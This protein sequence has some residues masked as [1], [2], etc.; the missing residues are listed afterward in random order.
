MSMFDFWSNDTEDMLVGPANGEAQ[1]I[2]TMIS[3]SNL[4]SMAKLEKAMQDYRA[5]AA[6]YLET[7]EDNTTGVQI[8]HHAFSFQGKTFAIR[9]ADLP[10]NACLFP[11][12]FFGPLNTQPAY[13]PHPLKLLYQNQDHSEQPEVM[14]ASVRQAIILIPALMEAIAPPLPRDVHSVT[15]A[16]AEQVRTILNT[17]VP[18]DLF[19]TASSKTSFGTYAAHVLQWLHLASTNSEHIQ[20]KANPARMKLSPTDTQATRMEALLT[21]GLPFKPQKK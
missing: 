7:N 15:A 10:P 1:N 8:L 2:S 9:G 20:V 13:T 21:K 6:I 19:P 4:N 14:A 17:T 11:T 18:S 3:S 16:I 12:A 5:L